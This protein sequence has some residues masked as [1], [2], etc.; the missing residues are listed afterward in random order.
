MHLHG[1]CQAHRGNI[2]YKDQQ[3]PPSHSGIGAGVNKLSPR[4]PENKGGRR[5]DFA[6]WQRTEPSSRRAVPTEQTCLSFR[7]ALAF[8]AKVKNIVQQGNR[9]LEAPDFQE[10]PDSGVWGHF[11]KVGFLQKTLQRKTTFLRSWAEH[12]YRFSSSF[13]FEPFGVACLFSSQM[14][15]PKAREF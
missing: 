7:R 11:G 10:S 5:A 13:L 1:R 6:N 9:I 14:T 3:G 2:V 12:I 15:Y 8:K 4:V